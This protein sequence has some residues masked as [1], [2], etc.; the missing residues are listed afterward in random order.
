MILLFFLSVASFVP[1]ERRLDIVRQ[2]DLSLDEKLN[3]ICLKKN[4][5]DDDLLDEKSPNFD[6][7]FAFNDIDIYYCNREKVKQPIESI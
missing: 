5:D 4:D 7:S 3:L 2:I 6:K 1:S